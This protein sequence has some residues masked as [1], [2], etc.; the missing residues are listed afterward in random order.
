MSATQRNKLATQRIITTLG[1]T[2][3]KAVVTAALEALHE[4][5]AWDVDLKDT[6]RQKYQEI[7]ALI[8]ATSKK[9]E[10]GPVPVPIRGVGLDKYTPY[11]KFDPYQLQWAYGNDQLRAVL[12]RGTQKD[13]QEAT[14]I[15]QERNP[16]TKPTSKSSNPAM[17]E[18]IL[19]HVAGPGY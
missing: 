17:I 18:Y 15:V 11:G 9:P 5:L 2:D 12:V 1:L 16:G 19:E 13:L 7:A 3:E 6:V 14:N 8:T 10:L 4:R